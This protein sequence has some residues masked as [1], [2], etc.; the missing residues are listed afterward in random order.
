MLQLTHYDSDKDGVTLHFDRGQPAVHAKV[1]VGADGYFSKVR[2][3]CLDD[4]PPQFAVISITSNLCTK[5]SLQSNLQ[6]SEHLPDGLVHLQVRFVLRVP[7]TPCKQSRYQ[8]HLCHTALSHQQLLGRLPF[9][10]SGMKC[11]AIANLQGC[12][13]C[14]KAHVWVSPCAVQCCI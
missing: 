11:W 2:A 12:L 10:P 6:A 9:S 4:G 8:R 3:Q 5:Y 1:L 14:Q 7:Q 13:A